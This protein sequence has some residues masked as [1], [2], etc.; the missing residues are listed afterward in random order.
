[1][2]AKYYFI[3]LTS[4]CLLVKV[5]KESCH[6]VEQ[7]LFEKVYIPSHG[8]LHVK[9]CSW[10]NISQIPS[11]YKLAS[12]LQGSGDGDSLLHEARF[13]KQCELFALKA[14]EDEVISS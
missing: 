9:H 14:L 3:S 8:R 11:G 2:E 1:M 13:I 4:L 7:V 12:K 10:T 6:L 5:P